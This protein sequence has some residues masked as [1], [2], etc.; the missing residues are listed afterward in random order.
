M[1]EK[2]TPIVDVEEVLSKTELYVEENKQSLITIA[3]IFIAIVGGYLAYNFI[4]LAEEEKTASS[5]MFTAQRYF[6]VDSLNKAID[7]DGLSLGFIEIAENYGSTKSGNLAKYY[8]GLSYLKLGNYEEA[9]ESLESFDGDDQIVAS[10]AIGAIGDAHMEMGNT[11]EAITY[12]LKAAENNNNSFTTPLFLKKAGVANEE[13]G[14]FD[15]AVK[16]Y[17]RIKN[18]F[19][20]TIEGSQMEKYIARAKTLASN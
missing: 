16:L 9:I 7:G 18:E 14:N 12:Y 13:L 17:E 19:G 10:Q 11:D 1:A 2:E 5:E 3:S 8:L 6:E 20:E 4:Y 15:M